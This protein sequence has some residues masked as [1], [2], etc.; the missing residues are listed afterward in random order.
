MTNLLMRA[1]T[2]LFKLRFGAARMYYRL[3]LASRGPLPF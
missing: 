3:W 2:N 1:S